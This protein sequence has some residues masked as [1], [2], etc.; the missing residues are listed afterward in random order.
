MSENK[1]LCPVCGTKK[2]E[3]NFY[4]SKCNWEFVISFAPLSGKQK[5][6]FKERLKVHKEM[7][8]KSLEN[9]E[10]PVS[11]T[12]EVMAKQTS[13]VIYA[14]EKTIFKWKALFFLSLFLLTISIFL[15]FQE[16]DKVNK[17]RTVLFDCK[18]KSERKI[19]NKHPE[20]VMKAA[21]AFIIRKKSISCVGISDDLGDEAMTL[22]QSAN[23]ARKNL[24]FVMKTYVNALRKLYLSSI[25]SGEISKANYESDISYISELMIKSKFSDA[26]IAARWID[27]KRTVYTLIELSLEKVNNIILKVKKLSPE[28]RILFKRK[29][30]QKAH[31]KITEKLKAVILNESPKN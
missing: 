3:N 15:F 29:Y 19:I 13:L 20:W 5:R 27:G 7:Y 14:F 23:D 24:S 28:F 9:D 10:T 16:S 17:F 25:K 30:S 11:N 1:I 31:Q 21:G 8:E 22:D 12:S 26:Q 2:G 6:E 4:C 18:N